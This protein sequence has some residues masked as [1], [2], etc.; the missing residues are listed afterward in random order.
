[1]RK[2]KELLKPRTTNKSNLYELHDDYAILWLENPKAGI[3]LRAKVDKDMVPLLQNWYWSPKY[4]RHSW[5]SKK[6]GE[7]QNYKNI[8]ITTSFSNAGMTSATYTLPKVLAWQARGITELYRTEFINGDKLDFRLE[9]LIFHEKSAKK[10]ASAGKY[11]CRTVAKRGV[12]RR[13]STE[14]AL[15]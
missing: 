11:G 15:K 9:N 6:T 4:T 7:V 5:T 1:M 10:K 12:L 8:N 3:E 13:K 14:N 2:A